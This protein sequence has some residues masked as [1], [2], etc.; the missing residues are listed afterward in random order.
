MTP[1]ETTYNKSCYTT[2]T[3]FKL[4]FVNKIS[5]RA[6]EVNFKLVSVIPNRIA[7]VCTFLIKKKRH[8]W[9]RV[10]NFLQTSSRNKSKY[11]ARLCESV[12]SMHFANTSVR[13][14][15]SWSDRK[16]ATTVVQ[17]GERGIK[18]ISIHR[19][20]G[21]LVDQRRSILVGRFIG[22]RP[23]CRARSFTPS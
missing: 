6:L 10:S 23:L 22:S 18:G 8:L 7:C 16:R 20:S 1:I 14:K 2:N 19:D 11:S 3:N 17:T 9:T 4:S 5:Q 12:S 15:R 13:V 21:Y